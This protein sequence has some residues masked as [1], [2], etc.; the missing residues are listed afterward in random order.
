MWWHGTLPLCN[1]SQIIQ[2]Y[3]W[4][5]EGE[6]EKKK[7]PG[8]GLTPEKILDE[9]TPSEWHCREYLSSTPYNPLMSSETSKLWVTSQPKEVQEDIMINYVCPGW[10]PGT[11]KEH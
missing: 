4:G 6:F 8:M 7:S 9:L 2:I 5:A 11:K 1:F 10:D 3:K